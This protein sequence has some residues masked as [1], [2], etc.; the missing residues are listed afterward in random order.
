MAEWLWPASQRGLR[1]FFEPLGSWLTISVY[2]PEKEH[3]A[4]V[5]DN[6]T[7]RKWAE[8]EIRKLNLEL[9]QRVAERSAELAKKNAELERL[10]QVFV[11]RKLRMI[12]RR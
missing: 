9:E 7:E 6:I 8:E 11:D 3:F 12:R 4:A 2:G 10:D 1:F 5:F